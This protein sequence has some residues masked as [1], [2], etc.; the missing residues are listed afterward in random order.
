MRGERRVHELAK[1]LRVP[2]KEVLAWLKGQGQFVKSASSTVGRPIARRVR[3]EYQAKSSMAGRRGG[4]VRSRPST[5]PRTSPRRPATSPAGGSPP[6][7]R[8]LTPSQ[9]ASVCKRFRW[10][11]ATGHDQA[12]IDQLY[13]ECQAQYGVSREALRDAVAE[14][15]RRYPGE[16]V[17]KRQFRKGDGLAH[18]LSGGS[19]SVMTPGELSRPR[20]RTGVFL[21]EVDA[22]DLEGVVDL[23]VKVKVSQDDRD[24][25]AACV[26]AF[27]PDEAGCY[28]YLAWRYSAARRRAYPDQSS[29]TA[30]HELAVMAHVIDTE[31]RLVEEVIHAHGAVLEQPVVAKVFS[32]PSSATSPT[33]TT[34][35]AQQP[36]SCAMCGPGITFCDLLSFS[37]S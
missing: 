15:L 16:Y 14:D 11:S 4:D 3:A 26:Q 2:A 24:E 28:G 32:M 9:K 20:P 6:A 31:K 7:A 36:M 29:L 18:R 30:H 33:S 5:K 25:I 1:E 27:V 19:A 10:A 13:S 37:S 17:V 34:S 35:G 8:H 21:P 12:A 23:I 22:A